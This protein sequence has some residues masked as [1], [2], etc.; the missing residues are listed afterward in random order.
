MGLRA[1]TSNHPQ[2]GRPVGDA[3]GHE[4][5]PR[6]PPPTNGRDP[7]VVP[8]L[9]SLIVGRFQGET[10]WG[11]GTCCIDPEFRSL[12]LRDAPAALRRISPK[13]SLPENV[14]FKFV[15]NSGE[16]IT[17]PLPD[18]MTDEMSESELEGVAGGHG[19]AEVVRPVPFWNEV[20]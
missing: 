11:L 18:P 7:E 3:Q 17:I 2:G 6:A 20:P 19:D 9:A 8:M 13:I 15:D 12:A 10:A 14:E 16:A 4:N 5:A 1:I